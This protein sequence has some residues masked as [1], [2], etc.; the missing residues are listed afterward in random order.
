MSHFNRNSAILYLEREDEGNARKIAECD[1]SQAKHSGTGVSDELTHPGSITLPSVRS[2]DLAIHHILKWSCLNPQTLDSKPS[3]L[4]RGI[5]SS[6]RLWT[7]HPRL[8]FFH[9]LKAHEPLKQILWPQRRPCIGT[10]WMKYTLYGY[11]DP[12]VKTY[13]KP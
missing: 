1:R 2:T 11:M 7:M 4:T 12:T 5:E 10:L 13:G 3:T 6:G 8:R 9:S